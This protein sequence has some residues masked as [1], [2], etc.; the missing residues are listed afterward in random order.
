MQRSTFYQ[1]FLFVA[2][3]FFTLI[4]LGICIAAVTELGIGPFEALGFGTGFGVL[5]K[6]L[7]DGWQFFMRKAPPRD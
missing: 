2:L 6:M 5:L 4:Y 1:P 3:L 7:S